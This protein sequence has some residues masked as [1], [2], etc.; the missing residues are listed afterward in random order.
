MPVEEVRAT[1]RFSFGRTTVEE[2]VETL[3]ALLPDLVTRSRAA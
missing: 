3:L 2:D 1:L